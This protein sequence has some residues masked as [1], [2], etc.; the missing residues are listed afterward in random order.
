MCRTCKVVFLLIRSTLLLLLFFYRSR[1]FHIGITR[2]YIFFEETIKIKESFAFS[3]NL[4]YILIIVTR[5]FAKAGFPWGFNNTSGQYG[6][7]YEEK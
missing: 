7:L 3:P 2:F 4:V 5:A 1:C 6:H